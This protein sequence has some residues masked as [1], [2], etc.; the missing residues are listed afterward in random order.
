M[1]GDQSFENLNQS[2]LI[3]VPSKDNKDVSLQ[4]DV[5]GGNTS[6]VVFTGAGGKPW[7]QTL[8]RKVTFLIAKL[9]RKFAD[10]PNPQR[11]PV[12]LNNFN[13]ETKKRDQVGQIG[14]GIDEK[15]NFFIDVAHNDLNGRHQFILRPDA[16]FDVHETSLT[17]RDVLTS[18]LNWFT[19]VLINSSS[20]AERLT[21][22]KRT[23]G[24]GFNKGGGGGG[25]GGGG[26]RGGGG[27]YG[28]G[29][30]GGNYGNS[31]GGGGGG[32]SG[33]TFS[34]GGDESN[35]LHL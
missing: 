7:K 24:G 31:G 5:W 18:I 9:I 30:G 12:H 10:D 34:G 19:D 20:T 8:P 11:Q 14:F 21:S 13:A 3:K 1:A 17:E 4:I 33:G 15:L 25:Y 27:N 23:G 22:F 2:G 35:E 6:L 16:R 32:R 29:G 28:G 26:N